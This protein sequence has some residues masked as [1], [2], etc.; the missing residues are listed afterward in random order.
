M[1]ITGFFFFKGGPRDPLKKRYSLSDSI[2]HLIEEHGEHFKTLRNKSERYI[3]GAVFTRL[4]DCFS[5]ECRARKIDLITL[6]N[7]RRRKQYNKPIRTPSKIHVTGV[8]R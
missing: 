4:L 5:I 7:Q 6:T 1:M 2:M 8:K 3:T